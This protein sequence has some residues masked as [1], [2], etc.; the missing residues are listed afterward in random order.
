MSG[1]LYFAHDHAQFA[2]LIGRDG[3]HP[4]VFNLK[5]ML[6]L[7]VKLRRELLLHFLFTEGGYLFVLYALDMNLRIRF[8][9][10]PN[11][12]NVLAVG[13]DRG[14]LKKRGDFSGLVAEEIVHPS[15][16][17]GDKANAIPHLAGTS[18][19]DGVID[20]RQVCL[21]QRRH[22]NVSFLCRAV[23]LIVDVYHKGIVVNHILGTVIPGPRI[24][25]KSFLAVSSIFS[26]VGQ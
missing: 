18:V 3:I 24:S 8:L 17:A 6:E 14:N 10:E 26:P 19:A 9:D 7:R 16:H 1:I 15:L 4:L 20:Q 11:L 22:H 21:I 25:A 12:E 23:L 13:D 5:R 2:V